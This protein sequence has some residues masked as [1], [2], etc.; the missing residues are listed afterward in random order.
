[1]TRSKTPGANRH[2]TKF[3]AQPGAQGRLARQLRLTHVA[4]LRWA[5]RGGRVPAERVLQVWAATGLT[6][7]QI[8]PDIYP[9]PAWLPPNSPEFYLPPAV[10]KCAA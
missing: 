10:E 3:L 9:D 8:R 7:Y 6:P 2:V 4:V 1:M 5:R